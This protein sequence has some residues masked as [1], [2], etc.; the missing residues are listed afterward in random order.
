KIPSAPKVPKNTPKIPTIVS[1]PDG[2]GPG[3]PKD[4]PKVPKVPLVSIETKV[5]KAIA[6]AGKNGPPVIIS[7]A[8]TPKTPK[9]PVVVAK[10]IVEVPQ[11]ASVST[12]VSNNNA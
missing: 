12:A 3:V 1:I 10:K 8:E 9:T 5:P 11:V 2:H 4:A 6:N 7:S